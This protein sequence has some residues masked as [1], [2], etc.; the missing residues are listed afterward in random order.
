MS[1]ACYDRKPEPPREPIKIAGDLVRRSDKLS[2]EGARCIKEL[3]AR[4]KQLAAAEADRNRLASTLSSIQGALADAGDVLAIREDGN[5]AE[6]VRE[7]VRQRDRLKAERDAA[8]AER[9]HAESNLEYLETE[10][11]DAANILTVA[12]IETWR[13]VGHAKGGVPLT[14]TQR[15]QILRRRAE[16][17]ESQLT[18]ARA[19]LDAMAGGQDRLCVS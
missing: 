19:Q 6:S 16:S 11:S 8:V 3:E 9:K 10:W 15:V 12:G 7:L 18:A 2:I 1:T 17:A 14:V 5:Y 4:L 13:E